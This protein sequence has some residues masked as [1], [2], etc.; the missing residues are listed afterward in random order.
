MRYQRFGTGIV[1]R[2]DRDE[3]I[4]DCL[5]QLCRKEEIRLASVTGLGAVKKAVL[6]V[7]DTNEK[8]YYKETYEGIY[9]IAS[10]TGNITRQDG[11]PYLHIHAVIANGHTG[12]IHGGHVNEA[13]IG[14]TGELFIQILDGEVGRKFSEEIRLNLLDF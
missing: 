12:E 14:A 10:L 13:V 7:F 9:E 4:L 6:G 8:V 1:L 3:E 2:V 11:Q 5:T